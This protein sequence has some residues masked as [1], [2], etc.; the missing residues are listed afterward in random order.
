MLDRNV[1]RWIG[2]VTH[3]LWHGELTI[4]ERKFTDIHSPSINRTNQLNTPVV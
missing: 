1:N 3:R 4:T 2:Y